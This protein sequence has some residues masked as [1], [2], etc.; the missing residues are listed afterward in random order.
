M[1]MTS[2]A[3]LKTDDGGAAHAATK[4]DAGPGRLPTLGWNSWNFFKGSCR[5]PH[6]LLVFRW[7]APA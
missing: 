5:T 4:Q 2:G 6:S 1:A 3:A 7:L